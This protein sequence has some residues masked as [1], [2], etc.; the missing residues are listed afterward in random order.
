MT[1]KELRRAWAKQVGIDR[2]KAAPFLNALFSLIF[3]RVSSGEEVRVS[4]FGK[5]V[6]EKKKAHS[7]I[8]KRV[9]PVSRVAFIPFASGSAEVGSE[10]KSM[11]AFT[12]A[13]GGEK[14]A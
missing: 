5:F 8:L 11:E 10:I 6:L 7:N 14:H 12:A 4:G 2:E 3:A 9:I 1:S 13:Q